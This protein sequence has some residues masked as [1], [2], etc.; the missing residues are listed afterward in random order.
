MNRQMNRR[1]F[2]GALGVLAAAG[3]GI[4]GTACSCKPT[5]PATQLSIAFVAPSDGTTLHS[6]DNTNP[7]APAGTIQITVQLAA[8]GVSPGSPVTLTVDGNPGGTGTVGQGG[9]VSIANVSLSGSPTGTAHA[10]Q[11]SVTDSG[12]AGHA[13]ATAHVSVLLPAGSCTITVTPADGTIFNETGATVGGKPTV[14]DE[15]P[16]KPGMQAKIVADVSGCADGLP[17]T[18]LAGATS[19]GTATV[20]GGTAVFDG[21]TLPDTP[22]TALSQPTQRLSVTASVGS[23]SSGASGVSQPVGYIVDSTVPTATIAQPANGQTFGDAQDVDP[24]TPGLQIF[25]AGTTTGLTAQI[26]ANMPVGFQIVDAQ[27]IAYPT[28]KGSPHVN[29]DGTFG[30]PSNPVEITLTNGSDSLAFVATTATGN[31]AQSTAVTVTASSAPTLAIISPST[32]QLLNSE[33]NFQPSAPLQFQVKL[34]TT[35]QTGSQVTLCST[36]APPSGSTACPFGTGAFTMATV[37]AAGSITLLMAT[38]SD[39]DQTLTAQVTDSVGTVTATPVSISVHATRPTV[40]AVAFSNDF[41][42]G[43]GGLWLNSAALADGGNGNAATTALVTLDPADSFVADGGSAQSVAIYDRTASAT[44][45]S[46]PIVQGGSAAT[47]SVPITLS[48]GTHDLEARVSDVWGNSN[49]APQLVPPLTSPAADAQLVVK[50]SLPSC[51]FTAPTG[52]YWNVQENGGAQSG[53]ISLPVSLSVTAGDALVAG[54]T[55]PG[56]VALS[57][58]GTAAGSEAVTSSAAQFTVSAGQGSQSLT[59][60]VTDPA[61]N[62]PQSC[63]P[64]GG[65]TIDVDTVAPTLAFTSPSSWTPAPTAGS[66]PPTFTSHDLTVGLQSSVANGQTV[67]VS[68]DGVAAASGTVSNGAAQV[69]LA[70]VYD[71]VHTLTASVADLAGN[72]GS[73]A[74]LQ[75]SVQ[76]PGCGLSFYKPSGNPLYFNQQTGSSQVILATDC[77]QGTSVQLTN[78]P[79]GGSA[80]NATASVDASGHATFQL[81]LSDGAQGTLSGQVT[82]ALGAITTLGPVP[83]LVKL[84]LPQL[85]AAAPASPAYVVAPN[86]NPLVGTTVAGV[87]YLASLTGYSAATNPYANANFQATA[88]NLGPVSGSGSL[89]SAALHLAFS[90]VTTTDPAPQTLTQDP[91]TVGFASVNL[92]PHASGTVTLTITDNAG[93]QAIQSWTVQTDDIPPAPP[94]VTAT[95]TDEHK[96][97]VQLGWSAPQDDNGSAVAYDLRWTSGAWSST[98]TDSQFFAATGVV[99]DTGVSSVAGTAPGTATTYSTSGLTPF[100]AWGIALRSVDAAGN[101]SEPISALTVYDNTIAGNPNQIWNQISLSGPSGT[102]FGY[103]LFTG[104]FTNSGLTDLAIGAPNFSGI[105]SVYV[106]PGAS[107]PSAFSMSNAVRL[108]NQTA[109]DW[110][111]WDAVAGNFSGTAGLAV[112]SPAWNSHQGRVDLFLST[113]AGLGTVPA[114]EIQGPT[115]DGY[116]GFSVKSIGDIDGDGKPDLFIG[117]PGAITTYAPG[118]GYIFYSSA[119]A[120]AVAGSTVSPNCTGNAAASCLTFAQ[121]N[122]TFTGA[123]GDNLGMRFAAFDVGNGFFVIPATGNDNVY[124]FSAT[125]VK[126]ATGSISPSSDSFTLSNGSG[127]ACGANAPP[128]GVSFHG[129]GMTGFGGVSLTGNATPDLVVTGASAGTIYIYQ[130]TASSV[131]TTPVVQVSNSSG[132]FGWD[133]NAP[134]VNQDGKPDLFVGTNN[135]NSGAYLYINQG[136]GNGYFPNA[137]SASINNGQSFFGLAVQ[138]GVFVSGT[139]VDLAIGSPTSGDV[140]LYY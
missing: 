54:A 118:A 39:G 116:F 82:D 106:I 123:T 83:Y 14:K 114:L 72:V 44:V 84:S 98:I 7:N 65:L 103:R 10:L 63:V 26:A 23:A 109:A 4:F 126:A 32:G 53:T 59:A 46:A 87:S 24:T 5:G 138:S 29:A 93:N 56:T 2:H 117:A 47:A 8:Q 125:A 130:T 78:T 74:G 128:C 112:G 101:R 111:G 90:G 89:G 135:T 58:N 1:L 6:S 35:A 99:Q 132:N 30:G 81:L 16:T 61:G 41:V 49:Y 73:A 129:Y 9:K 124:G 36:I 119:L 22:V 86:G 66:S 19:L 137:P 34:A 95:V 94:S 13:S 51:A 69:A 91:A 70:G 42:D 43:D 127:P 3:L 113:G 96:A 64:S 77:P 25:V 121:A 80:V 107:S 120:T 131:T 31:L 133:V 62:P 60:T 12:G 28:P 92:P 75:I 122:V 45:G 71:G 139:P 11:A 134:D 79:Q 55:V 67:T 115:T 20:T 52:G 50:T 108:T 85:S 88:A 100:N 140:I 48:N 76:A 40:Q 97:T 17:A 105:G 38:F 15:D 68:V 104:S 33:S 18:L 27:G 57:L 136:S 102:Y 37:G 21:V 110:F